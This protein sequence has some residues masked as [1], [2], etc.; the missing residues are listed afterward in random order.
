MQNPLDPFIP[1]TSPTAA[2]LRGWIDALALFPPTMRFVA[3]GLGAELLDTPFRDGGW[4]A[5]QIVHHVADSHTHA[6]LRVRWALAEERPTIKPYD[7]N[8]WAELADA[9]AAPVELSLALLEGV[10]GRLVALLSRLGPHDFARPFVHPESGPS[11]VGG[12]TA[13]YA[14][15]GP[16]HLAQIEALA[17][18]RGEA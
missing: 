1:P 8:R 16:H 17:R 15:H 5:R 7:E 12:L 4:T 11:T 10:H 13:L 2:D 3:S 6:L 14:W 9:R 18:R